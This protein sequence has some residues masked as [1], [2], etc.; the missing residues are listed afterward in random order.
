MTGKETGAKGI[1]IA[2]ALSFCAMLLFS[3]AA[4]AQQTFF[5]KPV[6]EKNL[7]Q[8]PA[9]LLY[10]RIETFPTLAQAQSAAGKTSLAGEVSGRAWLFTLGPKG[11]STPGGSKV[12]EIGPVPSITAPEYL[13]K[14]TMPAV[15]QVRRRPC[16]R[17]RVPKRSMFWQL[18]WVKG[19]RT[20]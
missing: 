2:L 15:P 12:A 4:A 19:H 3:H 13:L 18:E 7:K 20:A 5:V 9:G 6:A 14:S 1:I 11:G 17:I 16:T 10:W 8:L